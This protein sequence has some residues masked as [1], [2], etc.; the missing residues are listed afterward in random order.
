MQ[1]EDF[2]YMSRPELKAAAKDR[3]RQKGVW[4]KMAV[5]TIIPLAATL[6]LFTTLFLT[7]LAM[8]DT[9]TSTMSFNELY[10]QAMNSSADT[11]RK[12]ILVNLVSIFFTTGLSFTALDLIRNRSKK[13]SV[14]SIMLKCFN[15]RYFWM[16]LAVDIMTYVAVQ[17]GTMLFIIPGIL[18]QFGLSMSYLVLYDS[19]EHQQAGQ[20]RLDIFGVLAESYRMMRGHK[21]DLFVLQLSFIGWFL[22]CGFTFGLAYLWV[23]PYY[24]L[25]FAGFYEQVRLRYA[26]KQKQMHDDGAL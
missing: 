23:G 21:F 11:Q 15:S 16:V 24:E 19:R 25:T 17:F 6:F 26:D 13:I 2:Y 18:L 20:R 1:N 3:L 14:G 4:A 8:T 9:S 7:S 10:S 12:E 22:L 5:A